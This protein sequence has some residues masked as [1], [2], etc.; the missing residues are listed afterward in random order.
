MIPRMFDPTSGSVLINGHD[1][2]TVS[3]EALRARIGVVSQDSY[4]FHETLADNLRVAK[5]DATSEEMR[6]AL[7]RAR[8][9]D[10]IEQLPDGLQTVLGERGHRFSGGEKQRLAIARVFLKSPE[11]IIL[12]EATAHLDAEAE[13]SVQEA[14]AT[15]LAGR[16]ALVIAHRLSTIRNADRIIVLESGRIVEQGRHDEL[17]DKAGVY[18]DLY[19][20][21]RSGVRTL[22]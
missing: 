4:F 9:G 17:V 3:L 2:R 15:V 19:D 21:Y 18:A 16:S 11:L 10:L 1:T 22:T 14:L 7:A 20:A 8:I 13:R 6:E 5:P 12:D